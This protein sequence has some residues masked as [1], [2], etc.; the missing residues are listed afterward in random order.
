MN[1]CRAGTSESVE[2]FIVI[3]VK[4]TVGEEDAID[5]AIEMETQKTN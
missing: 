3:V 2:W 1:Q 4:I 5:L